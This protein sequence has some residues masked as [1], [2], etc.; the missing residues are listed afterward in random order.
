MPARAFYHVSFAIS[1]IY[2]DFFRQ[3]SDNTSIWW[4]NDGFVW[5]GSR[6]ACNR[7]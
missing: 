3:F 2:N 4:W 1:L 7:L 5:C 6:E